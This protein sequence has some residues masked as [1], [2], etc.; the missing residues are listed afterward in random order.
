MGHATTNGTM[1]FAS[2]RLAITDIETSGVDPNSHEI[3]EIALLVVHQH[4]LDVLDT[5]ELKVRPDHIESASPTALVHNGYNEADWANAVSLPEALRLYAS[6]TKDAVFC[7]HNVTFDW[8]F[9]ARA[10]SHT[11]VR[12]EMDYH[13][14]DLFT[15]AW[16]LLGGERPADLRLDTI[17]LHLGIEPEPVPHRALGGVW[18]AQRALRALLERQEG[19]RRM[20][21]TAIQFERDKI[22]YEQNCES[23]RGLNQLMW[24]VPV[25]AMTLTG[26]LWYGVATLNEMKAGIKTLL[27]LLAALGDLAFIVVLVRVRAVMAAYLEKI[28][29]F[30]PGSFPAA[31]VPGS[32]WSFL[33]KELTAKGEK[34]VVRTFSILLGLAAL[35]S[36]V[37][38]CVGL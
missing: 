32:V 30:N 28:K 29:D 27:L 24:Q 11:G 18:T 3:L 25:I 38:M 2:R 4:S 8:G 34:V 7:S 26:G 9:L 15:A 23:F 13:R 1:V 37:A 10:F 19:G 22:C 21:E 36:L 6:K 33:G 31:A 14:I 20:D 12:H 17:A 5:L 16:A 35:G